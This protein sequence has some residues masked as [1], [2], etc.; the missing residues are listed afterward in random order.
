MRNILFLLSCILG[1]AVLAAGLS[2]CALPLISQ[3]ATTVAQAPPTYTPLPTYTPNPTPECKACAICPPTPAP[4]LAFTS[5]LPCPTCQPTEAASPT[6]PPSPSP[7][8]TEEQPGPTPA[9]PVASTLEATATVT[10]TA[11]VPEGA[12]AL[13]M[14]MHNNYRDPWVAQVVAPGGLAKMLWEETNTAWGEVV[15]TIGDKTY[16]IDR[17]APDANDPKQHLPAPYSYEFT[18]PPSLITR[19]RN[20]LGGNP[21]TGEWWAGPLNCNASTDPPIPYDIHVKL[22]KG[23]EVVAEATFSF[24]VADKPTCDSAKYGDE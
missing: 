12:I 11:P 20:K 10:T 6:P 23:D 3:P 22:K 21:S 13:K 1:S 5:P 19:T 17:D 2:A 24:T 8:P 15:T 16:Q 9:P 18:F 14:I 4:G 7:R